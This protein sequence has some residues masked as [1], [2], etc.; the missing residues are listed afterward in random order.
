[1]IQIGESDEPAGVVVVVGVFDVE[2][3]PPGPVEQVVGAGLSLFDEDVTQRPEVD[4]VEHAPGVDVPD[5]ARTHAPLGPARAVFPRS[6]TV[7]HKYVNTLVGVSP[8]RHL[9]DRQTKYRVSTCLCP[10]VYARPG[11]DLPDQLFEKRSIAFVGTLLPDGSPHVIPTW[12]DF[13]GEDVLVVRPDQV[14]GQ[15]PPSRK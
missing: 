5:L 13:D 2:R 7:G 3:R 9:V 15:S 8:S 11:P 12:V 1:V 6:Y 4:D 10:T 14:N